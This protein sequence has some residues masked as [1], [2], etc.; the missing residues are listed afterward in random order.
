APIVQ[1]SGRTYPVDVYYRPVQ[2]YEDMVEAIVATVQDVLAE[3]ESHSGDFLVFLSGERDIRETA[4]ALRKAKIPHLDI[5]PL[6]ARLSLQE[7]NRVF[8][9]HRGRRVVLATNV[10]ETSI[11]VPGIRYVI[12]PGYAR[13]SRYS[14]RTKVLRLPIEPISQAS[15]N[16]RKGRSGRVANGVCI[17]LYEESDFN[18]RPE[19]TEP[20][21]LR[22]NLATVILQMAQLRLGE[23]RDFPFVDVPDK[24]LVNDG[25]KLL[26][27]L[28]ALDGRGQ[29]TEVGRQQTQFPIDPRF[30]RMCIAASRLG[31]LREVL[32]IVS[33]LTI[34][35]PRER[36][37]DKQ[38]A[39]DEKH[40]RF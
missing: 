26:E 18:A 14:Y 37:A 15:A 30:A 32:I 20:E 34:Q 2:D 7:Q 29:L 6:Y 1:V 35:D 33:G 10:A 17:R 8:H 13:I 27:E 28:Q 23:I 9:G 19:F 39:A 36:P 11:T 5:L 3:E 38:Q 40:R 24:R 21:I 31:C 12:D 16:Q 22:S 4:L 25:Y